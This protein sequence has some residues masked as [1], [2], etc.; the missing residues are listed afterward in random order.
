VKLINN[1]QKITFAW[2]STVIG[3]LGAALLIDERN[4]ALG[5]GLILLALLL[6]VV[7][8]LLKKYWG[9]EVNSKEITQTTQV[10]ET[11]S[12]I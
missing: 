5:I 6:E 7:R 10:T 12:N 9:I 3:S 1:I 8:E 4:Y 2:A 11:K